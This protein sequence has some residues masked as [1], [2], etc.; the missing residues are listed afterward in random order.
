MKPK[1]I[2]QKIIAAHL[3]EGEL[4]ASS[5][6]AI[7][8]D[9]TLTQDATGTMAYL[10]FEAMGLDRVRTELSVSYVDHNTLQS[11]FMNADDHVYLQ[12]VAAKYGI[13]FSRPGNGICHQVHLERFGQ[14][15]K[16]LLGS[17]SHTPTGGGIGMLAI[18]AGGLDVALAMAGRPFHLTMPKV[19][20]IHLTG[21]LSPFVSAKDIILEVLRRLTVKGGVGKVMEYTG[22]GVSTL[23]VPERATITNM[24]AELGATSSIFPSDDITRQFLKSQEREDQFLPLIADPEAEYDEI[25]EINLNSLE[26]MIAKPHMPDLVVSVRELKGT[27][28]KQVAMGSCTNSSFRDLSIIAS[29]LKGRK[30]HPTVSAAL[31]AGSRQVVSMLMANGQWSD[32]IA[33]GVRILENVCGP[34]IGMGF[35]PPSEAVSLRTFNRN[36][37]GRSGTKSASVYLCS[38]ETAVAA[39]LTGEITDPRDLDLPPIQISVPDQFPI[40]DSMILQPSEK[41]ESIKIIRGPNI[42]PLPQKEPLPEKLTGEV[43]LKVEDDITTDHIMPAGAKI[44]PLRSNIPAIS[45]YVFEVIDPTFPQRARKA[46]GG[47]VIGGHNYGQGSS[48]EHAAL[49]PMALGVK[50]VI[51]K[52]FARIHLANLINFGIIPLTFVNEADY[53]KI[54]QGDQLELDVTGLDKTPFSLKNVT[55]NIEIPVTHALTERDV[56]MICAGG[57]LSYAKEQVH[58]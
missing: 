11:G 21:K 33:S 52:S 37:T 18:G 15:G 57:A 30:V 19:V 28:V 1:N 27:P 23:S 20:Q 36:F 42:K 5:P 17:D 14:P 22:D 7:R 48:R 41:P 32:I 6:I 2:A 24:G 13:L 31:T 47:F 8:I 40:D 29:M 26:P 50:A 16:T 45:E 44:L 25:L 9:Q 10:Q 38:P 56:A 58:Q 12:S 39:A 54:D 35:S 46:G 34:C 53:E 51:T 3:I 55:Q 4:K 49:A 43:L